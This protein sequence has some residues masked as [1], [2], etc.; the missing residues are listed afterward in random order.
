MSEG[1]QQQAQVR[2]ERIYVKDISFESP[3]TPEV[4]QKAWK[5]EVNVE[6]RTQ[7]RNVSEDLYEVVLEVKITGNMENKEAIIIEV[8]QAGLFTI[9]GIS[10]AHLQHALQTFCPTTLFPYVRET[11][12]S[13]CIKGTLPPFMLAPVNFDQLYQQQMQQQ[14]QQQQQNKS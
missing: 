1:G 9:K 7:S 11:I 14:Q 13:L 3:A 8:E 6:L 12:D 10:G 2:I 4:F 5:P